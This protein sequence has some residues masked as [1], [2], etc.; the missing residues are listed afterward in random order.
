MAVPGM[1]K[2]YDA[3]TPYLPAHQQ[4]AV[5]VDMARSRGIDIHRLLRGTQLFDE[6]IR[7]GCARVSTSQ[8]LKL[9][10]NAQKLFAVD[11]LGFLYGSRLLP[12]NFDAL[13]TALNNAANLQQAIEVLCEFSS[14][15]TPLAWPYVFYD[16]K[17][18]YV[19][20]LG[21][22]NS[23]AQ[24]RFCLEAACNALTGFARLQMD[25]RIPW[26]YLFSFD[27]PGYSEQYEVNF[28][29]GVSFN[30]HIDL[31]LVERC[32]LSAPWV[33]ASQTA[34]HLASERAG[35]VYG[36]ETFH[37]GLV[38][39]LY[40]YLRQHIQQSPTLE[41]VARHLCMSPATF[42]RRLK[43]NHLSF[44]PLIDQVRKHV[45][46][47]LFYSQGY[48]NEQVASYLGFHDVNNF[49]RSF[50][51]WTGITPSSFRDTLSL[52]DTLSFTD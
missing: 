9:I 29:A 41:S 51:R 3:D 39:Y 47:Q 33:R 52:A 1:L 14:L 11:D 25:K 7:Q 44:Q 45:S 21:N 36:G 40:R 28:G 17:Y 4:P 2:L 20:W 6:D 24:K 26:R 16:D 5:L 50:K 30:A 34:F 12:G 42:K 46:F 32:Y 19:Q 10:D 18:C 38:D 43:A 35:A 23:L 8:Y 27:R 49:R 31:M 37:T 22:Y 48:S 13:S 15:L